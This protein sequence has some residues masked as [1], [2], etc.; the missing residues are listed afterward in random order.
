MNWR[1]YYNERK[2]SPEEAV[3]AIK[4]GDRVVFSHACGEPTCLVEAMV[5]RA[6]ELEAVEIVHMVSMGGARYCQPEYREIIQAQLLVCW[7]YQQARGKRRKGR[8]HLLLLFRNPAPVPGQST[9]G[10]RCA[11]RGIS[12]GQIGFRMSRYIR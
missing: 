2:V 9:A 10:R 1:T 6:E 5:D 8:L 12:A 3:K 7:L 4:S 11:Y